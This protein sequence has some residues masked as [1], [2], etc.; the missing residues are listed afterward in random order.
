MK[1]LMFL[2]LIT[3][4]W[5]QSIGQFTNYS[6]LGIADSMRKNADVVIRESTVKLVIRS[7]NSARYE[8]HQ[9]YTVL[10]EQGKGMLSFNKFSDKF[11]V[12][13][14]ALIN[15]FD[16]L[17]NKKITYNKKDMTSLNYGEGLVPEGKWTYVDLNVTSYPITVELNYTIK[18]KGIYNLPTYTFQYP[19]QSVEHANFDMEVPVDLGVRYKLLNTNREPLI[20]HDGNRTLYHWETKSLIAYPSEKHSGSPFNY[21]PSV[22]V[23]PVKFQLD[24]YEGDMTSWKNFGKWIKDLYATT[25]ELQEERKLFY[26]AL[27]KNATSDMEKSGILYHYLQNN[28]RYISIQLG[29]GGLR[30]F[31]ASFV[32]EKK[33]GDCKALSN[34]LK[35]ALDAVGIK[36]N[37]AII[38]GG[39]SPRNISE[40]FPA[41]YFNHVILCIP[42]EKDSTWL[43]CTSS[44]LPFAM[45]GPFTE[46]RKALLITDS[47]GVLVN[48]P[49]SNYKIN[50]ESFFT[51][52]TVEEDGGAKATAIC[53]STGDQRDELLMG[54]HNGKDDE[55]RKYFISGN[56][57]KQP[58]FID[59]STSGKSDDPYLLKASMEY[60]KVFSFKAG[61]K[62]FFDPRLYAIFQEEI[63]ESEQRTMDYYFTCPYQSFDTTVY[64]FPRGYSVEKMPKGKSI[65]FP[66]AVF[67]CNYSWD[68]G[69]NTLQNISNL[70]IRDRVIPAA[71]YKKLLDF[72]RQVLACMNEKIVM[73]KE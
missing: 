26:R 21:E 14:D 9:I 30:P 40:D 54:F 35:S 59:I 45:L 17:G 42:H 31:P 16:V 64:T 68:G 43:E 56:E 3:I 24:E 46:N 57:W 49:Q 20:A 15:V 10:N 69:S 67:T 61:N 71:D 65:T 7:S 23:G 72:K 2:V 13:D 12:L 29:I 62:Y 39:L 60:E 11:Q 8:V 33:Y 53:R 34:Y 51:R 32:D 73:K 25:T 44:S 38:Q 41:N 70:Q 66:F 27:V 28:M 6:L 18:Y 63:P 4:I 19:W 22:L 36:S 37:L 58:D 55:K 47:G 1:R 5:K 50:S 48:T 52:I